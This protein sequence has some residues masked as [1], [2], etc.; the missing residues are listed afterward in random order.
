MLTVNKKEVSWHY[1][2]KDD[3]DCMDVW[4]DT[5]GYEAWKW[6]RS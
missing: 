6:D 1:Q 3:N 2:S 4:W 5:E